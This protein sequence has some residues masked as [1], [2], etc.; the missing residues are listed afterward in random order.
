MHLTYRIDVTD[1]LRASGNE[2]CVVIRSSELWAREHMHD[3]RACSRDA[4]T[5]YDSQSHLRKARHQWGWDNAPR[6]L[7]SGIIRSVYIEQIP[8]K[9]FEEVY[10]YTDSIS[11]KGVQL[12]VNWI[13]RT[14]R[15][16][17]VDHRFRFTL[18]DG[19][20]RKNHMV[21]GRASYETVRGWVEI[22]G[23][24]CGF[25]DEIRELK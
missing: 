13:Y 23:R 6:L 17:L 11:E 2:L 16:S 24:E 15:K 22:I 10:L 3:M 9:H 12:G 5:A 8:A 18:L 14:D 1:R 19:E 7:T 21:T 20:T 25:L 4:A